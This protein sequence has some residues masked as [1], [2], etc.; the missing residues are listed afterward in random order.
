MELQ[1]PPEFY[2]V[3]KPVGCAVVALRTPQDARELA[4]GLLHDGFAA[5]EF[6]PYGPADM[7]GMVDAEELAA[8]VWAR[9][10]EELLVAQA[11]RA[12]AAHGCSFLVV[13]VP[14]DEKVALVRGWVQRLQAPTA[15]LYGPWMIEELTA[16]SASEV[17]FDDAPQA[18]EAAE[19]ADEAD[20]ADAPFASARHGVT[21]L[22]A[23]CASGITDA[24][25][26]S[27]PA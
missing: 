22:W 26:S 8:S 10:E 21:P 9:F 4:A 14:T 16:T 1:H 3:F 19:A 18:A 7:L 25:A 27:P 5:D 24:G 13:R 12:L 15:Q 23:S 2:G 11:H 17:T 20:E 6:L